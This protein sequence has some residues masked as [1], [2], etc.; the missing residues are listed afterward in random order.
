MS[1]VR[2]EPIDAQA[3]AAYGAW[4]EPVFSWEDVIIWKT[5]EPLSLDIAIWFE[6]ELCGLCFANPNNSRHRIRIVRL[7]GKPGKI[8]PLKNRIAALALLAIDEFARTI[9][10]RIIEVQEPMPGAIPVYRQLGFTFDVQGRLVLAVESEV[11]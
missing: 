9:G 8:H 6:Q 2:F 11:S 4:E 3:L 10:S 5:R 7:E 1:K